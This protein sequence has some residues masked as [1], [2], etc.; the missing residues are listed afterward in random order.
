M[1]K[2]ECWAIDHVNHLYQKQKLFG[3][4]FRDKRGRVVRFDGYDSTKGWIL[5]TRDDGSQCFSPIRKFHQD[6]KRIEVTS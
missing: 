3:Q 1:Q 5:F 6:Y 2:V 4:Y